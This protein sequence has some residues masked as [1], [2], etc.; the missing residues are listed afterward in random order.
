MG[1]DLVVGGLQV[2]IPVLVLDVLPYLEVH[3]A[4][5]IFSPSPGGR[6]WPPYEAADYIYSVKVGAAVSKEIQG[7]HPGF[8]HRCQN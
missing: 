4:Y 7:T 2:P 6:H 8:L 1:D 5:L 3:V